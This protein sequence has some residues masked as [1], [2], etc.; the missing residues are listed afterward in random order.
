MMFSRFIARKSLSKLQARRIDLPY[1]RE[2]KKGIEKLITDVSN[3]SG[4]IFLRLKSV[5]RS[6]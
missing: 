1:R 3:F 2:R 6:A 5:G 4:F